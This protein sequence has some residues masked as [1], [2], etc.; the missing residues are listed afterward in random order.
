MEMLA[1]KELFLSN[2]NRKKLKKT[3]IPLQQENKRFR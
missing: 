2:P 1:H 3:R